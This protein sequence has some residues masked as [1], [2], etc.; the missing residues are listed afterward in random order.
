MSLLLIQP[1]QLQLLNLNLFLDSDLLTES[2]ITIDQLPQPLQQEEQYRHQKINLHPKIAMDTYEGDNTLKARY[3][4]IKLFC[5]MGYKTYQE[6]PIPCKNI[7]ELDPIQLEKKENIKMYQADFVITDR[8]E[9]KQ[10]ILEIDGKKG[11]Y[12]KHDIESDELRDLLVWSVY[13]KKTVR[14]SVKSILSNRKDT[15]LLVEEICVQLRKFQKR[16]KRL[17]KH[18]LDS[19]NISSGNF[20]I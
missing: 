10:F 20:S 16:I 2:I 4:I 8:T 9:T 11:H 18:R 13:G 1:Q 7:F 12:S 5:D 14:L 15:E 3:I 6:I 17:Q 19:I